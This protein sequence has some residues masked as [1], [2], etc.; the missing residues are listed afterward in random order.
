MKFLR[1]KLDLDQLINEFKF[2]NKLIENKEKRY[3][4]IYNKNYHQQMKNK[5]RSNIF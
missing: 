4:Y 2:E 1:K 5:L 3:I